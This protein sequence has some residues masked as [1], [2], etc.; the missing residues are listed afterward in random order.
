MKVIISPTKRMHTDDSS[1]PPL[2]Q[3]AYLKETEKIQDCMAQL[4]IKELQEIW[5]TSDNLTQK[6]YQ[7]FLKIDLHRLETPALFAYD[8]LVFKYMAPHVMSESAYAYLQSHLS[9]LSGFFGVLQPFDGVVPY[10]LEMGAHLPINDTHSL[11]DFWGDRLY[12]EVMKD[13]HLLIN[14]ASQEYARC[15]YDYKQK[16][17]TF[18]DIIFGEYKNN[19]IITKATHAKIA[20]GSMISY[21]ADHQVEKAEDLY[22]FSED[23]FHFHK[24]L[25]SPEKLVYIRN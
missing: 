19:K 17:D 14:L 13:D 21:M 8:G 11:Y 15:L 9:I 6:A 16:D 1:L 22:A 2:S 12:K 18:I 20:R 24:E 23:G 7:Q 4:S 25:S 3:P 5:K 10:R